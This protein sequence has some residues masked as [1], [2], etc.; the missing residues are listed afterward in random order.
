MR[1]LFLYGNPSTALLPV[2]PVGLAYVATATRRAGHAVRFVD[3]AGAIRPRDE[4]RARLAAFAPD[5]VG[6][7]IRNID[8]AVRQRSAWY[9][10]HA[11][12]LASHRPL[13]LAAAT[14]R[15]EE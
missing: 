13:S 7:S 2:P 14:P 4:L 8:N 6:I 9:L 5:V 15:A 3:L 10:Q 12:W 1:V 11:A